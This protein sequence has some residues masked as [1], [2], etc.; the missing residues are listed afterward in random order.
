MEELLRL[1]TDG[2]HV[3]EVRFTVLVETIRG[4]SYTTH[5]LGVLSNYSLEGLQKVHCFWF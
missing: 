5:W 3:N 1:E 4:A 2:I